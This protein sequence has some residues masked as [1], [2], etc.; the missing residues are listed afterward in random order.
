MPQ[1]GGQ[2]IGELITEHECADTHLKRDTQGFAHGL[3][4][5][6]EDRN[7][8]GSRRDYDVDQGDDKGH[9]DRSSA[10][11]QFLEGQAGVVDEGMQGYCPG[12]LPGSCWRRSR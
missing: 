11:A 5:G 8:G 4:N 1:E 7:L 6:A 12:S 10:D 3:D 9:T 2:D